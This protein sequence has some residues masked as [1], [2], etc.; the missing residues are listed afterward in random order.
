M[1][2]EPILQAPE[3]APVPV[4]EAVSQAE[5]TETT[6][7]APEE[8]SCDMPKWF[9]KLQNAIPGKIAPTKLSPRVARK[10]AFW[11]SL[12]IGFLTVA[13][14]PGG[15]FLYAASLASIWLSL[16]AIRRT[17]TISN[18]LAIA[19]VAVAI[20]GITNT[21]SLFIASK[22]ESRALA[23]KERME[24]SIK[25]VDAFVFDDSAQ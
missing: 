17:E 6:P 22:S 16:V 8:P 11:I 5:S 10:V 18:Q 13:Q 1:N 24:A 2:E 3:E 4:A 12:I 20:V 14:M 9:A 19:I 25:A 23:I 7:P 21:V 15:I